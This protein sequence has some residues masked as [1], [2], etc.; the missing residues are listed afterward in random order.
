MA[1]DVRPMAGGCRPTTGTY[2]FPSVRVSSVITW[3]LFVGGRHVGGVG[4]AI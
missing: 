4:S 2:Y 1:Q 3:L